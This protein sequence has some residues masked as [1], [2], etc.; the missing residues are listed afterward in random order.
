MIQFLAIML[1]AHR[2]EEKG[3]TAVEYGLMVA[4][5]A[6]VIITIV[7]TL[8]G[9][10]SGAVHRNDS[11]HRRRPDPASPSKGPASLRRSGPFVVCPPGPEKGPPM[12]HAPAPGRRD[13]RG[14]TAVEYGLMV[15][16]HRHWRS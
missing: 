10:L 5:I 6:V 1:N 2:D 3:A 12:Q 13:E 14:A 4:L 8:G 9:S 15:A 11:D 7:A 16:L